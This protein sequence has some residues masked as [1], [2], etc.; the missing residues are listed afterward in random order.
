MELFN[1]TLEEYL[2]KIVSEQQKDW[3]EQIVRFLLA[4]QYAAYDATSRSPAKVSFGTKIKLPGDLEFSTKPAT[5]GDATYVGKVESL[6]EVQIF[7]LTRI[8][9]VSDRMKARYNKT[10]PTLTYMVYK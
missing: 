3:D 2:R 8:K 9:I 1:K 10:K 4:Y 6:N 5:E 7:V